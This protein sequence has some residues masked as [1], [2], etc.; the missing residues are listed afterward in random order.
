MDTTTHV[1]AFQ[2]PTNFFFVFFVIV[3]VFVLFFGG[4]F[5]A[6]YLLLLWYRSRNR[7]TDS[8]NST[9]LQVTVPRDNEI[10]IDAAEQ[11]FSSLASLHKS[12]SIL[13]FTPQ[14][15]VAFEIVGL[16]GDIRFYIHTPNK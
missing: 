3:L 7:E 6:G 4:F 13:S 8:L 11:L 15:H 2:G 10:K 5:I 14:Q 1:T 12:T 16:P 9:L